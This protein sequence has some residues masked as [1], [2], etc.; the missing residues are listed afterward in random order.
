MPLYAVTTLQI[1]GYNRITAGI[2]PAACYLLRERI[3]FGAGVVSGRFM[4]HLMYHVT[5]GKEC[6]ECCYDYD[7]D[8]DYG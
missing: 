5:S 2:T 3:T 8:Y 4:C 7:Y 6:W 1:S